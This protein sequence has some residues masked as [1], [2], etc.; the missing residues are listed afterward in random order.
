LQTNPD[1]SPSALPALRRALPIFETDKQA[2]AADV[3]WTLLTH[4]NNC[5]AGARRPNMCENQAG[6]DTESERS[7]T[8]LSPVCLAAVVGSLPYGYA[9]T[10]A[11]VSK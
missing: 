5:V 10:I 8:T 4:V 11:G 9:F 3:S 1:P 2:A 6:H 7:G